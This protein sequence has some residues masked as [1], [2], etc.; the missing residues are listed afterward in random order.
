MWYIGATICIFNNKLQKN[1]LKFFLL[2]KKRKGQRKDEQSFHKL[3]PLAPLNVFAP[4]KSKRNF[5]NIR[6]M[7]HVWSLG[8]SVKNTTSRIIFYGCSSIHY[9]SKKNLRTLMTNSLPQN[10]SNSLLASHHWGGKLNVKMNP[11]M[12]LLNSFRKL[13]R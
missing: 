6:C 4:Q 12:W 1:S 2:M 3:I 9:F 8:Q 13:I 10:R 11:R 5:L 7:T